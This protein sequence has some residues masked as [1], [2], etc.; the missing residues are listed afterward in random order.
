[1]DA[2][3]ISRPFSSDRVFKAINE[4]ILIVEGSENFMIRVSNIVKEE[5]PTMQSCTDDK[6]NVKDTIIHCLPDEL[7]RNQI[8]LL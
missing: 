1:M 2:I 8:L 7:L 4:F 5:Y 6:K 3:T